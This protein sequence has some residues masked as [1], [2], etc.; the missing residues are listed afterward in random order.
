MAEPALPKQLTARHRARRRARHGGAA[1]RRGARPT[2]PVVLRRRLR[3]RA[4]P[5]RSHSDPRGPGYRRVRRATAAAEAAA[6]RLLRAATSRQRRHPRRRVRELAVPAAAELRHLCQPL[7]AAECAARAVAGAA[8]V[9]VRPATGHGTVA[10]EPIEA[11]GDST[12]MRAR[13]CRAVLGLTGF[14]PQETVQA[15]RLLLPPPTAE[16][17]LIDRLAQLRRR[18]R[19]APMPALMLPTGR[20]ARHRCRGGASVIAAARARPVALSAMLVLCE[21]RRA[22]FDQQ[23][24]GSVGDPSDAPAGALWARVPRAVGSA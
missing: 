21:R 20:A 24:G 1:H 11:A 8:A 13:R 16:E 3:L 18:R 10:N 5:L 9:A 14:S 6:A 23:Y 15:T 7:I 17:P 2:Q 22:L 19:R 4:R 12:I